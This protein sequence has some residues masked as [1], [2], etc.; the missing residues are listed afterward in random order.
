MGIPHRIAAG[1]II[2]RDDR[3]LLVRYGRSDGGTYL[4]APGGGLVDHE[5]ATDGVVREVEEETGLKVDPVKLLF[6]ED[7]VSVRYKMCKIWFLC[8]AGSGEIQ[9]T[10][11]AAEEGIIEARWFTKRELAAETVYPPPLLEYDWGRFG[12]IHG[13]RSAFPPGT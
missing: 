3:I 1:G 2:I 4:A 13:G 12:P 10:P 11:G 7:L 9:K 8:G 5:S 6:I